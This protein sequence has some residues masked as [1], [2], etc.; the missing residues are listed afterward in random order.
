MKTHIQVSEYSKT[1]KT[2]ENAV[3]AAETFLE[4]VKP[5]TDEMRVN[6]RFIVAAVGDR[7]SP[8]FCNTQHLAMWFAQ[9]S[10]TVVG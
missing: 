10:F 5:H 7:Y 8:V 2:Y 9:N 3:K 6:P 4:K 1:Y